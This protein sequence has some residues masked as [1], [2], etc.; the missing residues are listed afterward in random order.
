[1]NFDYCTTSSA[2]FVSLDEQ[3]LTNILKV[4]LELKGDG[5]LTTSDDLPAVFG[6]LNKNSLKRPY[7]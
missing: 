7:L 1:M 3:T 2:E 5:K 6:C 4:A